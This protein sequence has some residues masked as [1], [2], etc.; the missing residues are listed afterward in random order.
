MKV[1]SASAM[2]LYQNG[3]IASLN[4]CRLLSN[5]TL[6]CATYGDGTLCASATAVIRS[7][8]GRFTVTQRSWHFL[9]SAK[10]SDVNLDPCFTPECLRGVRSD[11]RSRRDSLT[12]FLGSSRSSVSSRPLRGGFTPC[13]HRIEGVASVVICS[14][15]TGQA[16]ETRRLPRGNWIG[17]SRGSE[18]GCREAMNCHT[19]TFGG[20]DVT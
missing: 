1:S 19:P 8:V 14:S 11:P 20:P 7:R 18:I 4:G 5:F 6:V 10:R 12:S 13:H 16:C 15:R 3:T 17:D 2:V 9:L